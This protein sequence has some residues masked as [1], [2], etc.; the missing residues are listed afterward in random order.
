NFSPL[1]TSDGPLLISILRDITHRQTRERHRAARHTARR[2]LAETAALGEAAPLLLQATCESLNWDWGALWVADPGAGV[3]RRQAQWHRPSARA[4]EFDG[5]R[6]PPALAP[7]VG[8]P[9]AVW[10]SGSPGWNSLL[11][12]DARAGRGSAGAREGLPRTF[13]FPVF[14]G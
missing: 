2:V 9:G 3:L 5:A 1:E 12:R 4:A 10:K 13:A 11:P 7:G 6:R 8:L 14:V